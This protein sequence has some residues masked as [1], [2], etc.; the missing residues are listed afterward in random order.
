MMVIRRQP[1][2][3]A[4]TC[5]I[6]DRNH[7][8]SIWLRINTQSRYVQNKLM[9]ILAMCVPWQPPCD[10]TWCRDPHGPSCIRILRP[11]FKLKVR[12]NDANT[13]AILAVGNSLEYRADPGPPWIIQPKAIVTCTRPGEV[14]MQGT[15]FAI[16]AHFKPPQVV[17]MCAEVPLRY[18]EV[19]HLQ[20]A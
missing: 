2:G 8:D 10:G 14:Q 19:L 3:G 17:A 5:S 9:D 6:K 18:M 11:P 15:G 12:A 4:L 13:C 16:F 1:S 7:P 20:R